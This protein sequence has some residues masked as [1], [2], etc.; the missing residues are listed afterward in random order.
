M[1]LLPLEMVNEILLRVNKPVLY[2]ASQVCTQWKDLS[3][4]YVKMIENADDLFNVCKE[5]D[6]LSVS[7]CKLD[8]SWVKSGL[9]SAYRGGYKQLIELMILKGANQWDDGLYYGCEPGHI[10]IVELMIAKGSDIFDLGLWSPGKEGYKDIAELMI[11]KGA[12]EFDLVLFEACMRGHRD[13]AELMILNGATKRRSCLDID[14]ERGHKEI[15][16]LMK[17]NGVTSCY[18][19]KAMSEH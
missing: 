16:E 12:T 18:C 6:L 3:L 7:K 4:K 8:S 5:G 13:I 2:Y 19:G 14:C 17:N 9:V 15:V 1:E 11:T 10:E